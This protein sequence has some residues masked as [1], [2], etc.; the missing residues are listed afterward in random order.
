MP[1]FNMP[2]RTNTDK[3]VLGKLKQKKSEKIT[4]KGGMYTKFNELQVLVDRQFGNKKDN[5][6]ILQ[7]EKELCDYIDVCIEN[8]YIA[9]DTETTG[10]DPLQDTIA[11]I[12]VYTLN[13]KGAYIPI[14]HISYITMERLNNQ[15]SKNVIIEQFN[16]LLNAKPNIDMFNAKFD[17]RVLKAF[18]LVNVYCTWDGYLAS[19]VLNENEPKKGLKALHNKYVLNGEKE[20]VSYEDLFKGIPFTQVPLNIAYLYAA[21]D[22]VITYELC[23]YQRQYLNEYGKYKSLYYVFNN[24]EMACLDAVINMEDNGI[25]FDMEYQQKLSDKYNELLIQ[26]EKAFHIMK[27]LLI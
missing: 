19:R 5:F 27:K 11:G 15:I 25:A 7:D 2:K 14:N 9:I 8:G 23:E 18:G 4:V 24:I 13:M 10:L 12:C 1:L 16:R 20:A 26:K 6:I 17:I 22:P 21:N 3:Q